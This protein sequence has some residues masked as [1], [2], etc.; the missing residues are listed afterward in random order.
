MKV[1]RPEI[2]TPQ[3]YGFEIKNAILEK[4]N[5]DSF[6]KFRIP[7]DLTAEEFLVF[8]EEDLK[9]SNKKDIINA[10][11][12]IKRSI[13]NRVD[14]LLYNLGYNK[15]INYSFPE[16]IKKLNK[17]GIIA[18]RILTEINKIRNLLEHKYKIPK[19]K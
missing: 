13:E 16:K 9:G 15:F 8:A 5:T 1:K 10:L 2:K 18:P 7:F 14:C 4:P 19:K 11:S 17:I 6:K 12:N 3:T